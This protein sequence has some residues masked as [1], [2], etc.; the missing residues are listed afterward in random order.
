M[1]AS[2]ESAISDDVDQIIKLMVDYGLEPCGLLLTRHQAKNQ[3]DA[4]IF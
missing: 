2:C 3:I 1:T 4:D